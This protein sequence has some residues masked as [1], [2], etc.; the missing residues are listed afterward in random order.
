MNIIDNYLNTELHDHRKSN[1]FN[2]ACEANRFGIPESEAIKM[3]AGKASHIDGLDPE[4]AETKIQEAYKQYPAE[5]GTKSGNSNISVKETLSGKLIELDLAPV[6]VPQPKGTKQEQLKK[7]LEAVFKPNDYIRIDNDPTKGEDSSKYG[8]REGILCKYEEY[9]DDLD[10]NHGKGIF[11]NNESTA[12]GGFVMINPMNGFIKAMK[13]NDVLDHRHVLVECDCLPL[14]IQMAALRALK[15]PISALVYSG[16]RSLH[17]IVKIEAGY[18]YVLYEKRVKIL[19]SVLHMARIRNDESC[20]NPNRWTRLPGFLRKEEPQVNAMQYLVGVNMG[21]SSWEEW[22]AYMTE[23]ITGVSEPIE[24]SQIKEI[25]RLPMELVKGVLR[26]G[27]T[28]LLSGPSKQGKSMLLIALGMALSSGKQWLGIPC[29]KSK[30]MYFNAE[31]N[32]DICI[33]RVN[34]VGIAMGLQR[35]EY[36]LVQNL[37]RSS[38]TVDQVVKTIIRRVQQYAIDVVIID[39][40]YL[41]LDDEINSNEVKKF[42]RAINVL[43][44]QTGV[45]VVYCHHNNKGNQHSGQSN[46]MDR[47][48]GSSVFS[49]S[50]DAILTFHLDANGKGK[51]L[52]TL[53]SFGLHEP[54]TIQYQHPLFNV[55]A[56]VSDAYQTGDP[57]PRIRKTPGTKPKISADEFRGYMLLN[58]KATAEDI[59]RRFKISQSLAYQKRQ[60]YLLNA[61]QEQN[62]PV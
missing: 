28:L 37:D 6:P 11:I 51:L 39:P 60:E 8:P 32:A 5:H 17:A 49:R 38:A 26:R 43:V 9:M 27:E 22:E 42:V 46:H 44:K 2:A 3:L 35:K 10:K 55:L 23:K 15:L 19:F 24:F 4:T 34:D 62:I 57:S 59:Q 52:F 21:L 13:A 50:P 53:R 30:V 1:L 25:P 12:R 36:P 56:R 40:I 14:E 29:N 20:K 33:N 31:L 16:S 45:A 18:D 47:V 41:L 58:P 54:L 7:Y 61:Q 48:S